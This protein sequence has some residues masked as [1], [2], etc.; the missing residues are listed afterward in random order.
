MARLLPT[1]I[2]LINPP[3]GQALLHG[4]RYTLWGVIDLALAQPGGQDHRFLSE[5]DLGTSD[6][7]MLLLGKSRLLK[8]RYNSFS[9]MKDMYQKMLVI[10]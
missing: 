10:S 1:G 2:T 3:N 9:V 4:L 7:V 5:N 8:S 6:E